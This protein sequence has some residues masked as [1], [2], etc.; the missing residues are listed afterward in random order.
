[1]PNSNS[2]L[3]NSVASGAD[4]LQRFIESIPTPSFK[5]TTTDHASDDRVVQDANA[6][7][8]RQQDS[9][10][11]AKKQGHSYKAAQA[12]HKKQAARK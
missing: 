3:V 10:A 12:E 11:K 5:K 8:R 4:K 2:D 1:M 7:F 9:T 6:S